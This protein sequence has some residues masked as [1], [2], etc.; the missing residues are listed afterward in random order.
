MAD[1][2]HLKMLVGSLD[3]KT[4]QSLYQ[5]LDHLVTDIAIGRIEDQGRSQNLRGH[6]H[7]ATTPATADEEFSIAHGLGV[8]PYTLIPVLPVDLA[9][10]RIPRLEVSRAADSQRVY[11]KSPEVSTT[12][13][14]LIEG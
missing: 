3:A 13:Y 7:L 9:G 6:F 5:V 4:K 8:A 2:G 14:A 1:L 12:F 11:L 10:A